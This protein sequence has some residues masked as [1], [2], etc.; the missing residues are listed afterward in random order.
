VSNPLGQ[1]ADVDGDLAG[2]ACDAPGSGNINCDGA[3]N[4]VDA[5]GVLRRSAGLSVAQSEPCLDIGLPRLL[6]PPADELMGDVNCSSAVN[7]VDALLILRAVAGLPPPANLPA[8]CP[9]IK[10]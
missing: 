10:P 8:G 7:S 3:V 2:D 6:T 1:A 9:A 4:S 5:L